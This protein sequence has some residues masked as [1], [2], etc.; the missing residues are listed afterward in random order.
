[1]KKQL[2]RDE[3]TGRILKGIGQKTNINGTAGAPTKYKEGFCGEMIAFFSQEK[4]RRELIEETITNGK[5]GEN[6][7]KKWKYIAND[8]PF[9]QAFARKIKVNYSTLFAWAHDKKKNDDG[10]NTDEFLHPE[11]SEAYNICKQLQYEFLVDNG[12]QGLYPP[13]SFIF[14]AKNITNMKDKSDMTLHKGESYEEI[15]DDELKEIIFG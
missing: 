6:T 8:T 15:D 1:M 13:A 10:K 14:V 9:F 3:K 12:L 5:Y 11:F 2:I 4:S 7:T